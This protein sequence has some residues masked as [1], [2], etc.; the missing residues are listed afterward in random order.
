MI[1]KRRFFWEISFKK[2]LFCAAGF[3][4]FGVAVNA[5]AFDYQLKPQ[6]I[7]KN[8]Y[9]VQGATEDFSVKNGGN[10]VNTAFIM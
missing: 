3:I 9:L 7:A 10:I 4:S 8:T 5:H 1:E 2:W 6:R